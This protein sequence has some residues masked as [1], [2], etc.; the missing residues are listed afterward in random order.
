MKRIILTALHLMTTLCFMV[1]RDKVNKSSYP[2]LEIMIPTGEIINDVYVLKKASLSDTLTIKVLNAAN[3]TFICESATLFNYVQNYLFYLGIQKESEP[4][5]WLLQ[6][7]RV[8][9]A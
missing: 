8:V 7:D 3:S 1:A 9:S 4:P 6:T 5:G 2:N